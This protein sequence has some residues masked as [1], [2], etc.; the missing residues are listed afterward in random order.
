MEPIDRPEEQTTQPKTTQPET[1]QPP[2]VQNS[3]IQPSTSQPDTTEGKS[4][5]SS[6]AAEFPIILLA[7]FVAACFN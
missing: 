1:T 5:A 2:T 6:F 4:V 3:T 7:A